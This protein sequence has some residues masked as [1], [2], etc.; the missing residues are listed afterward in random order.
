MPVWDALIYSI[1]GALIGL[2]IGF[3]I[4]RQMQARFAITIRETTSRVDEIEKGAK[5]LVQ[6]GYVSG[7]C[8]SAKYVVLAHGHEFTSAQRAD[9]IEKCK[10]VR[11]SFG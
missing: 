3:L 7:F 9:I 6:Q 4:N 10:R 2:L 8:D 1:L 5:K 11:E